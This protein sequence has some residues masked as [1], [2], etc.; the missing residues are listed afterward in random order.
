MAHINNYLTVVYSLN[1]I[2][3]EKLVIN[4]DNIYLVFHYLWV[5]D[6]SVA[7]SCID[8]DM[9][10]I[11]TICYKDVMLVLLPNPEGGRDV[12]AM[13]VDALLF[14]TILLVI[15]IALPD[16][17]L[18]ANIRSIEDIY[19]IRVKPPR[20]SY[21][22]HWKE[23]VKDIPIFRQAVMTED[24][25]RTMLV[26]FM[27]LLV[28]YMVRRGAG[29]AVKAVG[30]QAQLQQV[31]SHRNAGIF[32]AYIN[33]QVQYHMQAAFLGQPSAKALLKAVTHISRH[34]NPRAPT[35][36][37]TEAAAKLPLDPEVGKLKKLRDHLSRE[38][39]SQ[40]GTIG[41]AEQT[42]TKLYQLYKKASN[43]LK[44]VEHQLK[45]R[46]EVANFIYVEII[47]LDD[48]TKV[49]HRICTRN[50]LLALCRKK[51]PPRRRKPAR[52]EPA[53]PPAPQTCAKTQYIFCF[54]NSN[55]HHFSSV[56][57]A[58]D[59]VEVHLSTYKEDDS[60]P[61]P[62]SRCAKKGTLLQ[63]RIHCKSHLSQTYNYNIFRRR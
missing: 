30:T 9:D 43:T 45:E 2:T 10:N 20:R 54:R 37:S 12:L 52:S 56:Y 57:K 31:I 29:E 58:R 21:K 3:R 48:Q 19:R 13:E 28:S 8:L 16:N 24:G 60:I 49:E 34:I 38:V 42:R 1:I 53:P 50:A 59:H 61:C 22:F 7:S 41:R 33:Q 51:E 44:L 32:Q 62:E 26:G 6:T 40:S 17:A 5:K 25:L 14:D 15:I 23:E 47:Q 27:Q 46:Q 63:G 36:L 18:D 4:V 39:Q 35:G 11:K 55:F